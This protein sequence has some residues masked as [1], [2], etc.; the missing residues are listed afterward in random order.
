MF[1]YSG[2]RL[3]RPMSLYVGVLIVFSQN[4]GIPGHIGKHGL[5]SRWPH[6]AYLRQGYVQNHR[7]GSSSNKQYYWTSLIKVKKLA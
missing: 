5:R 3:S 1:L 7:T 6:R 4:E 2:S